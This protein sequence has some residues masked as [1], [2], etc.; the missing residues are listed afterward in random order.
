M[1]A[2]D[3]ISACAVMDMI[4]KPHGLRCFAWVGR[5][6]RW[7]QSDIAACKRRCKRRRDKLYNFRTC[8]LLPETFLLFLLSIGVRFVGG[9]MLM[10]VCAHVCCGRHCVQTHSCKMNKKC[11]RYTCQLLHDPVPRGVH[12]FW[13]F[14]YINTAGRDVKGIYSLN[15]VEKSLCAGC[16]FYNS[17]QTECGVLTKGATD[18]HALQIAMEI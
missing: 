13:P 2:E 11:E 14:I 1:R 5:V 6:P 10:S 17:L 7:P 9:V 15:G 4:T 8:V 3:A 16:N 18:P 12:L